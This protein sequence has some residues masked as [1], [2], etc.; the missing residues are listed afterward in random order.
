MSDK[1]NARARTAANGAAATGA[2]PEPATPPPAVMNE[3]LVNRTP[4]LMVVLDHE[5]RVSR[6]N[7]AVEALFGYKEADLKG[8][9]VWTLGI[10]DD[11]EL[12]LSRERYR[13]LLDGERFMRYVTRFRTAAGEWRDMELSTCAVP[14]PDGRIE[15]FIITGFDITERL[16]L[17]DE[18]IRVSEQEQARIGHD[19][20]DGVGQTLTGAIAL[21]EA[22]ETTL[23]GEPRQMAARVREII[24][25]AMAEVRRISHGLSPAAVKGRG[26]TG[27]LELL[28][29]SNHASLP[30]MT[31]RGLTGAL[32]LLA[33]T[34]RL[35]HRV[36]C[37]CTLQP[38]VRG[39]TQEHDAHLVRIAQEAVSNAVRHGQATRL[40]LLLRWSRQEGL[41]ELEIAN[42]GSC[43]D[44][45]TALAGKGIGL[46]VMEYRANLIGGEIRIQSRKG[47]GVS[48]KC[49]FPL[50]KKATKSLDLTSP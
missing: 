48:V 19:L 7:P 29:A 11:K 46:R 39:T 36:Q 22:L 33:E 44:V 20:H 49:R 26:L 25:D 5:W 6:V 43:F 28:A 12:A 34:V 16:R 8:R 30:R 9:N 38:E 27:A 14:S 15:C 18:V 50:A 17:Q 23:C 21:A 31:R 4:M 13:R 35:T 10:M 45:P 1:T 3:I 24:V 37:A 32:E 40:R 2:R 41:G 47:V 42:N